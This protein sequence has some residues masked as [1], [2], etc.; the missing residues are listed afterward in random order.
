MKIAVVVPGRF[1]AFDLAR[2]LVGRGHQVTLFTN[3]PPWAVDRFGLSR[4]NVHSFWPHGA[5]SRLAGSLHQKIGTPFPEAFLYPLFSRWASTQLKKEHWDVVHSWG[6]F[7]EEILRALKNTD[8]LTLLMWGN[9]HIR[10][11]NGILEEEERRTKT[12]IGHPTP[13][14][15]HRVEQEYAE[16]DLILVFSSFSYDSFVNQGVPPG[17][18]H[19]L[20]LGTQVRDFRPPPEVVQQRCRRIL[21][22]EPLRVLNIGTFSF[23][24]GA[25][26]LATI[27]QTVNPDR[28]RFRFVGPIAKEA[29]TLAKALSVSVMFTSQQPQWKLPTYYAWGDLFIF[30]TLEDGFGQVLPEAQA[31][32]LPI[33]ASTHCAGTD[34]IKDEES[35]WVFP[36]R[37][38]EAFIERLLWCDSHR[39]ELADMIWRIYDEFKPRDWREVA[40]DFEAISRESLQKKHDTGD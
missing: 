12:R 17:K 35:G 5:I 23:R 40:Q 24:K 37:S 14:M 15:I 34:L 3:Y 13:W 16:T 33:L 11:K 1:H 22:G 25:W 7:S 21:S 6:E 9:S 38:P 28:F 2:E 10:T 31:S 4:T 19:F 30:P 8:T 36:I 26:D 27:I 18:L 29:E 20:P 39:K 32:A